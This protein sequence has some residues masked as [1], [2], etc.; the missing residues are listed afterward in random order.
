MVHPGRIIDAVRELVEEHEV[1]GLQVER[2]VWSPEVKAARTQIALSVLAD[3]TAVLGATQD[4]AEPKDRP[5]RA[6]RPGQ[7]LPRF[8]SGP[9]ERWRWQTERP[10]A[11]SDRLVGQVADGDH[12]VHCRQCSRSDL[13]GMHGDQEQTGRL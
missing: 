6:P 8:E 1:L 12:R 5:A 13:I 7:S 11:S 2:P 4:G 9:G 10:A 3:V